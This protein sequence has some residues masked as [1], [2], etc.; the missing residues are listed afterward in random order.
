MDKSCFLHN[1]MDDG[2]LHRIAGSLPYKFEH[3]TKGF[4][5]LG[6]YLKPL[7]YLV[8]DWHW[9]IKKFEKRIHHWIFHLLSIGGS[10]VLMRAVLT[11]FPVYWMALVPIPQSILDKLRSMIFSFL[12]GSSAGNRKYHLVDWHSLSLPTSLGG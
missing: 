11:S 6:Y 1:N 4:N 12:W 5:Y 7:G 8:K 2:I 9:L 3:I 10:L